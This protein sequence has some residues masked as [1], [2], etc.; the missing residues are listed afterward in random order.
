MGLRRG[1]GKLLTRDDLGQRGKFSVFAH[2]VA[3][4]PGGPRGDP[5]LSPKLAQDLSNL[6]LMC[7]DHHRLI[8]VDDV[9]D[10]SVERLRAMKT[11]HEERV[12]RLTELDT[13]TA[14]CSC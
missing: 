7:L 2:I 3:D 4:E 1:E 9:V 11:R 10:H 5:E 14:R 13:T 12:R 6:M 8:D